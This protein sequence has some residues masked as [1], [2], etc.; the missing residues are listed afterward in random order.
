ML[1][2]IDYTKSNPRLLLLNLATAVGYLGGFPQP[3][4]TF[5][6]IL[7]TFPFIKWLLVMLLIYQGGGEQ[8]IRLASEL[9]LILFL[10]DYVIKS[11]EKEE[12]QNQLNNNF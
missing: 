7:E 4:K 6:R 12:E 9:T 10:L 5:H 11:Y 3:P 2:I 1:K 8:D